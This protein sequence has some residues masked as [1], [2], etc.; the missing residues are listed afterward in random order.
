[1]IVHAACWRCS[2]SGQG[3]N[4]CYFLVGV[5]LGC[6]GDLVFFLDGMI[7][8]LMRVIKMFFFLLLKFAF[9]FAHVW[10]WSQFGCCRSCSKSL[11]ERGGEGRREAR[12][13]GREERGGK[14]CGSGRVTG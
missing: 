6:T 9:S 4:A 14:G 3:G 11:A 2:W 10:P 1:M 7:L 12:G 13:Q 8:V 5:L